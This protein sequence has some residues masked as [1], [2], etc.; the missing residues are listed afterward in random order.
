MA[1]K[2]KRSLILANAHSKQRITLFLNPELV[3]QAKAQ[4]VAN[5]ASLTELVSIALIRY[6]PKE[7]VIKKPVI[8]EDFDP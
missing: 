1:T 8:R 5:E 4:A 2:K 7:T 3:K 6:L